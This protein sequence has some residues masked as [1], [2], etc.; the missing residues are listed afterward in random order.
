MLKYIIMNNGYKYSL[1]DENS[2]ILNNFFSNKKDDKFII[3]NGE[4]GKVSLIIN[5]SLISSIT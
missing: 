5:V 1:N 2:E 3:F 4:D